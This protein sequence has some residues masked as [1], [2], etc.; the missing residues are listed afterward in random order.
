MQAAIEAWV[1][2]LE[3]NE[4]C[5]D[6]GEEEKEQE[7]KTPQQAGTKPAPGISTLNTIRCR[8]AQA[9]P[10]ACARVQDLQA[11]GPCGPK[12]GAVRSARA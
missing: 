9:V 1:A 10:P 11:L 2:E 3:E 12:A 7:A 5:E 8:R 6:K 4:D